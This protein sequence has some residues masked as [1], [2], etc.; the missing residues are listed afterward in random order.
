MDNSKEG[1]F[2]G[3][4]ESLFKELVIFLQGK[5]TFTGPGTPGPEVAA[6]LS[7]LVSLVQ[8]E[9]AAAASIVQVRLIDAVFQA[10]QLN[11]EFKIA[12]VATGTAL[13]AELA[14]LKSLLDDLTTFWQGK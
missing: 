14:K 2:G 7:V 1:Y 12:Q 5:A 10:I 9:H 11:D 8:E 6:A 3:L 13:V 4:P